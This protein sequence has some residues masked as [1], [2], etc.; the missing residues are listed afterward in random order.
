MKNKNTAQKNFH[1]RSRHNNAYDF[2]ALIET[3]PD[4]A[5]FILINKMGKE[6]IDFFNPEAVKSLNK[7]LLLHHYNLNN[8]DIPKDYLCPPIPSRA[9]YIHYA[10]DLLAQSNN[11]KIPKGE[12]VLCLD[13]GVGA[14][15]IYPL[16]G[17]SF[18][19]WN[20]IGSDIEA[21]ALKIAQKN[22]DYKPNFQNKI[23][24]RLQNNKQHI[25]KGLIKKEEFI[26]IAICNPPF[27]ASA[28]E[29]EAGTIR[30][31]KNLKREKVSKVSLNFGGQHNELWCEG[32][33]NT[34]VQNMIN[35]SKEFANNCC[36][37]TT[38]ISKEKNLEAAYK[39]LEDSGA[40]EVLTI[41]MQHGNKTSRI[42]AWTFLSK[43]L[44]NKWAAFRWQ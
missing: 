10:A 26:D 3:N 21:S 33:E 25:F 38:L 16:I 1:P 15:C 13:I 22:I 39:K 5:P 30:K 7:S 20:F 9:D 8:W 32:G 42:L 36:W 11:G 37:F 28:K 2:S 27:H 19:N 43:D 14:N 17:S 18:Y 12:N 40:K 6:S 31:L 4:L 41:N 44:Q 29:A 24:L 35:E 34:F 23:E